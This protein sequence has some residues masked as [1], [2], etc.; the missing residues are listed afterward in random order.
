MI[1]WKE[2]CE[3]DLRKKKKIYR[4]FLG[5]IRSPGDLTSITMRARN[6]MGAGYIVRGYEYR[7][8][9]NEF[10]CKILLLVPRSMTEITLSFFLAQK[11]EI[12]PKETT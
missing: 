9:K 3:K 6:F 2:K 11:K 5:V 12:H 4:N 7:D 10:S 1:E 8:G